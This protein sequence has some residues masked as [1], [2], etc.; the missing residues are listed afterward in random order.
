MKDGIIIQARTGST[1]LPAKILLPFYHEQR[2][3]DILISNIKEAC[4]GK[5]IILATT[6]RE[7]DNVLAGVAAQAGICCYRGS[8]ENVL[9]RFI[10]AAEA[11]HLDRIVRVC[12]DNPFLQAGSFNRLLSEADVHPADYT[13][14]A[15]ADGRPT[16][17]SHLGLYA[18]L[19]TSDAL[20]R[21]AALTQE[22]LYIEHVTIYLYSHPE[23]FTVCLLPLPVELEGRL[24]LRFT[25]DTPDD[26]ALLQE[27]YAAW[28]EQTDRSVHALL[29]WVEAHP[30]YRERMKENIR[31]NEK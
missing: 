26:F 27:L 25:L 23:Q 7:Q 9:G 22:P 24:D 18:E 13:A 2:I 3:I 16:I 11:F 28:Y 14:F 21:V 20:R 1:R 5:C 29:Q 17:K 19:T 12:S 8:E 31:R 30:M 4:P 6:D 15:F 10:G